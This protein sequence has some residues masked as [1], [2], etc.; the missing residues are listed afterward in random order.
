[1]EFDLD[2]ENI[3]IILKEEKRKNSE[4]FLKRQINNNNNNPSQVQN[5]Q[6]IKIS[7]YTKYEIILKLEDFHFIE[8]IKIFGDPHNF[9]LNKIKFQNFIS[10]MWENS[11]F[12]NQESSEVIQIHQEYF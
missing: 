8:S 2:S 5:T 9:N 10:N 3:Q 11:N 6:E 7:L 4:D 12:F 1:M